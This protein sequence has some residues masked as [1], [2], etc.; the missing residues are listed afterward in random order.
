MA[1]EQT[2]LEGKSAVVT[3]GTTGIGRATARLLAERGAKVLIFGRHQPELDDALREIRAASRGGEDRVLGIL[4]DQS[5][6][7]DIRRVFQ[8]AERRLG[9]G[10]DILINNAAIGGESVAES[11]LEQIRNIVESNL[12]GYLACTHEA[13]ARMKA[14]KRGG[15]IVNV[16]SMSADLREPEGE[17]YV[18]TKAGI[19]AFSESLRKTANKDHIRV[20][21]I[22]PGAVATPIQEK[23]PAEER[24]RIADE[25][26]LT[27]DDIAE[28]ILFALTRPPRMD[29]VVVQA[30]PVMQ[31]I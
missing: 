2:S 23:S 25:K 4:A 24:Q 18:A 17:I 7:E 9:G 27:A 30:R 10:L 16:G 5:K 6:L 12:V 1:S 28:C 3:G 29:I 20:T 14:A 21:L 26:M 15:H 22:E 11:S 8:E 31:L 19:Q 13:I